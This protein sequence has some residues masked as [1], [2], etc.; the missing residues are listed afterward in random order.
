MYVVVREGKGKVGN[1]AGDLMQND[2]VY[3]GGK[4][5]GV[6]ST[7]PLPAKT[8]LA[9]IAS[10]SDDTAVA[11]D[12]SCARECVRGTILKAMHIVF[13]LKGKGKNHADASR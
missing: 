9:H 5:A 8:R 13:C 7:L 11:R 2:E 10:P 6:P 12:R 1:H 3:L 4:H